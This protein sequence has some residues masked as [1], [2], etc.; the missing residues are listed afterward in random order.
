MNIVFLTDAMISKQ[1]RSDVINGLFRQL[2]TS[3]PVPPDLGRQVRVYLA[4]AGKGKKT[5]RALRDNTEPSEGIT[6]LVTKL[7]GLSAYT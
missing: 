2:D 7:T 5:V 4:S 3:L 1:R 6:Y